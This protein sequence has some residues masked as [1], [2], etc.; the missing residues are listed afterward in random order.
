MGLWRDWPQGERLTN[1]RVEQILNTNAE[2]LAVACPYCLQMFEETIKSMNLD[3]QVM[4]I[5]EILFESL[6]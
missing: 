6:D 1:F 4:D 3:L 2:L 5:A